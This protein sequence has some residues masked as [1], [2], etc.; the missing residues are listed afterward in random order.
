MHQRLKCVTITPGI[1]SSNVLGRPRP[2]HRQQRL[3]RLEHARDAPERQACGAET[4]YLAIVR[5]PVAPD[6]MNWI[7][8]GS[9]TVEGPVQT[10]EWI[11]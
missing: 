4:N 2:H 9:A 10:L 6:D 5:F 3:D 1:E 11:S 7:G 8:G